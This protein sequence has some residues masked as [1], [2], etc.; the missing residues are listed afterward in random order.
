MTL[1]SWLK[2][3]L[4]SRASAPTRKRLRRAFSRQLLTE[5]LETRVLMAGDLDASFGNGGI[6]TTNFVELA[7]PFNGWSDSASSLA[8]QANGKIVV[9]GTTQPNGGPNG[10]ISR[11]N[12]D[13]SLDALFSGDG[14][15]SEYGFSEIRDVAIQ[16]NGQI[17][18]IGNSPGGGGN[19]AVGRYNDDGSPDTSF[20]TGGIVTTVPGAYNNAYSVALL[21]NVALG[22]VGKILVVGQSGQPGPEQPYGFTLQQFNPNG[23]VDTSFGDS[24][25]VRTFYSTAE[26]GPGYARAGNVGARDLAVQPDGKIIVAGHSLNGDASN[27][28]Q[29][30][31]AVVRYN[32]DGSL[33]T[34]FDMD[35][36][37]YTNLGTGQHWVTRM[38]LQADGK[39]I[40]GGYLLKL[41]PVVEADFAMVRYNTDGSLDTT[42]DGDGKLI[43]DFG[44][45]DDYVNDV[46]VQS[47]GV[48]VVTGSVGNSLAVA[49][50]NSDGSPDAS[51]GTNGL[52]TTAI[53][54]S[55]SG[56]EVVIQPNGAIVVAGT[57]NNGNG[58]QFLNRDFVVARYHGI[59]PVAVSIAAANDANETGSVNGRFTISLDAASAIDT[60]V[61][62]SVLASSSATAG[63]DYAT[64]SGTLTIPAGDLSA[65]ITVS[66][67]ANDPTVEFDETISI[68]LTGSTA[69]TSFIFT[70][71]DTATISLLDNDSAV[72]SI[73]NASVTEGN[74]GTTVLSYP[75]TLSNPVDVDV[76][77]DYATQDGTATAGSD[78]V[79]QSGTLI[80][81]AGSTTGTIDITVNGDTVVELNETLNVL[82]SNV[83]ASG[84]DVTL[85]GAVAPTGLIDWGSAWNDATDTAVLIV[86]G[87]TV[88]LSSSPG[89]PTIATQ[90][91]LWTRK[92]TATNQ[93]FV[94]TFSEPVTFSMPLA[95]LNASAEAVGN[96]SIAP[97]SVTLNP[98]H[99]W[100]GSTLA[101]NGSTKP[102]SSTL[103]W[104]SIT[105]L[106][107]DH[108]FP[109][110][111]A[112]LQILDSL[113]SA[114]SS[115][116]IGTIINNDSA[117]VS[118]GNAS[119]TEG[120]SSTT[121]LS[122]PV[123]LSN[124]VDVAV[125]VSYATQDGT[126]IAGSDYVAQSGT[127]T[128]P[129]GTTTGT[130][131][132]TVNGDTAIELNETLSVLLSNVQ[133]SGR[134]VILAGAAVPAGVVQ[135]DASTLGLASGSV[136][137]SWGGQTSGG[138][139]TLLAG[140]TPNGGAAVQFNAG[141]D[142]M[143]DNVFVPASAAGD[144]I[145][146]AVVK[147]NNTGNY[148]NLVDDDVSNRPMLWIDGSFNY[149]MNFSGGGGA[150]AVG[151]GPGG[152]DI[153]IMDSRLN[154]LYVNST[155]PNASG[156]EAVPFTAGEAFD[157]F[158]RDGGQTFQGLVA[159]A[160]IYNDRAAFG[161][162]FAALYNELQTKWFGSGLGS[163]V[164]VGTIVNDDFNTPPTAN[165]DLVTTDED[166]AVTFNVLGNDTD[167]E[168][169]IV[170]SLTAAISSP[171]AGVLTDNGSGSF[172]FNTNGAFESL[173]TGD[174]AQ[175]SFEYRIEDAYGA[176]DTATVTITITGVNDA[177]TISGDN[178]GDM[179]EDANGD[180]GVL[181]VDDLDDAENVF[182]PVLNA[183]GTYG[184]FSI[185]AAGN[186]SYTRTADLQSLAVG[187]SVTDSFT[188]TSFDGTGTE[189]VAITITGENDAPT[190]TV[191]GPVNLI[192]NGSFEAVA[193]GNVPGWV[194]GPGSMTGG[195]GTGNFVGGLD[196]VT[197]VDG[198]QLLFMF[199]HD[200]GWSLEQAIS[201]TAGVEHTLGFAYGKAG[202]WFRQ[203]TTR[204][205]IFLASNLVTPIADTGAL[206]PGLSPSGTDRTNLFQAG[207]TF[208]PAE[209][210]LVI[211][212]TETSARRVFTTL[213]NVVLTAA[214][215]DTTYVENDAATVIQ[216]R[217][218]LND[219][220]D[221]NLESATVAITGGFQAGADVL[222]FINQ[223]GITGSYNEA[224]GVLTLSG[225]AT[226]AQYQAA[227]ASVTYL[228]SSENPS[229]TDRTI[230]FIVN[231][232]SLNSLAA[233]STVKV[234][235]VNDVATISG[236]NVGAM[237]EDGT[238]DNGVLTVSDVDYGQNVFQPVTNAAGTYGTFSINAAGNWSYTRTAN[239]QSLAVGE[240]VA[241]SFTV[242][243]LDGTASK[244]VT[245]TITGL[246]DAP[247]LNGVSSNHATVSNA[248]ANGV[249]TISGSFSDI[250]T[251]DT[252]VA[253]VNWG[254]GTV[255]TVSVIQLADTLAG[256][257]T[258]QNGGIYT[259]T[260][261]VSDG[262]GGTA[263]STTTAVVQGVGIVNGTLYVI[264]T[265]GPD[266]VNLNSNARRNELTINVKLNQ[267][268]G[269]GGIRKTF[270]ISSITRIDAYLIAGDDQYNGSNA[271][272]CIPNARA[273]WAI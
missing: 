75:V 39:M 137:S 267:T 156:G 266:D 124:P 173:A 130:I 105:S 93:N 122:F 243:S 7:F 241:D 96:F 92:S 250:D 221:T 180:S 184:T 127:L 152:W 71:S 234:V 177:A 100:D 207:L 10:V 134:D 32:P 114:A 126:A 22:N 40:L 79:A 168:N 74:S 208:T 3:I 269:S 113:V 37:A 77:I 256:S 209:S 141:G 76:S 128:I 78:Y 132:I 38:A 233:T 215:S 219:V 264:G 202:D 231:D 228:N 161:G 237:T 29:N 83:Q 217:L 259:V 179:T 94:I 89:L 13:G 236:D 140:Q 187:S 199:G 154:Q 255:A 273:R 170:A 104:N 196:G 121:V 98:N 188:V 138:T 11:Y 12:S 239:L 91:T 153:V 16:S 160:R 182:Q 147:A 212:F 47:D 197:G 271:T 200:G 229:E 181:T 54:A 125:S 245:I 41:S 19:F 14:K 166:N 120:N 4:Q 61:T 82:L 31:F 254:D 155:T 244:V 210:N 174:S 59:N 72:M 58:N 56:S 270:A 1:K 30:G 23:T 176:T 194:N 213:D 158:H 5:T 21:D 106:S 175:V 178:A 85:A 49:R 84:R 53:Q 80:I 50:F 108:I 115:T 133:A 172:T 232:G 62:Y 60:L 189:V 111:A 18:V 24:G 55:A 145:Y 193:V 235:A 9:A 67:I 222:G 214:S 218:I 149:E 260:V 64:L 198:S 26:I 261:S 42:F 15:I 97:S 257:H 101:Y 263:S 223:N 167:A 123:T 90:P 249:V 148:H 107:F 117:K 51:F 25:Q 109:T 102:D 247:V 28:Y 110:N 252:H 164:G 70:A 99:A 157:F 63:T 268:G 272:I 95:D 36:R 20:G 44:N 258:Y 150:K 220:D 103:T 227:L 139:P 225:A 169:N 195:S 163:S 116:T 246:N 27:L 144:F 48:I 88:T 190:I 73:G 87:I 192:T 68:Q 238:G 162:D 265:D 34:S 185:N 211:R 45:T 201:S 186:W 240:S 226:V 251:S 112:E 136:V 183:A 35:G 206:N 171:T 203:A 151:T 142:R 224:S 253:T 191:G 57:V 33:D 65:D 69:G 17:V 46:K 118:I 230:S 204:A 131:N 165:D 8:L 242:I 86:D 66:G 216:A 43:V 262:K 52:V 146:V 135:L 81:P 248:S 2:S 143:G 159:E 6:V 119:V 205:Q 129:A